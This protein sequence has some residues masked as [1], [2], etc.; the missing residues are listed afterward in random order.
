MALT[1][2]NC[3]E[4]TFRNETN[5]AQQSAG[6][7]KFA[8]DQL[9]KKIWIHT[10]DYAYGNS[11]IEEI[12]KGVDGTDAEIIGITKPKLG[13]SDFGPYIS[14]IKNSE[15]NV[16]AIPLTGGPLINFMKQA[17]GSGLKDEVE[18]IGTALFA[19]LIRGALGKA[20]AGTYSSTLYHHT[21]DLGDNKQFV[22]NYSGEYDSPPGSFAR[23]G[24][25]GVRM[26]AR[27]IQAA[28]SADPKTVKDE[29]P[30][31]DFK[32]ILG[33]RRFRKCDHQAVNPVWSSQLVM[34]E[35]GKVTTLD[36]KQKIS[37]EEAT[38]PCSAGSCSL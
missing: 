14:Q 8:I 10:A 4:Y 24:Y 2:K 5:T 6:L 7:T 38:P 37:A 34:P 36:L 11:A 13:E 28:E 27:G 18:I 33:E 20:A 17:A 16:L 29:L 12:K 35:E 26:L 3:N 9:G 23:V 1:G 31:R 19:Q 25:E 32:T 21:L 22:D 15:A 30:G